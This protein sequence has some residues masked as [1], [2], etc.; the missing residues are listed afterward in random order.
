M[1]VIAGKYK[2]RTLRTPDHIRPTTDRV[3]ETLFNILQNQIDE[4]VFADAFAGSGTVGIE[5][6]SRGASFTYFL[7]SNRKSLRVLDQNLHSL[8]SD[9]WR[10]LAMD[11]WK[12]I[13]VLHQQTSSIDI[14]F[15]DPPYNFIKYKELLTLAAKHFPQTLFI[16]EHSS[17]K[18]L[19]TP[20]SLQQIRTV[21]IGETQLSFYRRVLQEED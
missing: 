4:S 16:V 3:R 1:R 2:S 14:F 10:I 11:V 19:E 7:E 6:I 15:F 9:P 21:S 17:R 5:A 13:E 8:G 18:I 20:E 12:G